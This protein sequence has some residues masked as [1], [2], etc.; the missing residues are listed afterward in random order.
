[1]GLSHELKE[2][3]SVVAAWARAKPSIAEAWFFGSRVRGDHKTD[4]DLDVALVM[5]G[6]S[7]DRRYTAWHF[8]ADGWAAELNA[9]L[10][11]KVD[12]DLGDP[13][14]AETAV[15]PALEREGVRVF[16]RSREG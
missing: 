16:F 6:D 9:L 4:S 8:S 3:G 7:R 15:A 11:V 13:D 2:W 10:P 1:M 5:V 14:I 12:L